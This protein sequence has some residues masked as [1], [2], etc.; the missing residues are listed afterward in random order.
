MVV[1]TCEIQHYLISYGLSFKNELKIYHPS[2]PYWN[3]HMYTNIWSPLFFRIFYVVSA[4]KYL[5]LA[6]L[7]DKMASVQAK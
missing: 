2:P 6:S 5:L 7:L 4:L 1:F 3:I